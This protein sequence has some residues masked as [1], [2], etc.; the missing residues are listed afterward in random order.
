MNLNAR[1]LDDLIR[2]FTR[3]PAGGFIAGIRDSLPF[4]FQDIIFYINLAYQSGLSLD[5]TQKFLKDNLGNEKYA[6][7]EQYISN[8][9]DATIK[10]T[11][12]LFNNI[13]LSVINY[14]ASDTSDNSDLSDQIFLNMIKK[15]KFHIAKDFPS[16]KAKNL[17]HYAMYE[18]MLNKYESKLTNTEKKYMKGLINDK[19]KLLER[20]TQEQKQQGLQQASATLAPVIGEPKVERLQQTGQ[21]ILQPTNIMSNEPAFVNPILD[22]YSVPPP[23]GAPFY[24]TQ[25]PPYLAPFN[26]PNQGFALPSS[27]IPAMGQRY[28]YGLTQ[29]VPLP[30]D[31]IPAEK[32]P[33]SAVPPYSSA[34]PYSAPTP[35]P[36]YS[37]GQP[38]YYGFGP[39]LPPSFGYKKEQ[40][41][42]AKRKQVETLIKEQQL[43]NKFTL[44]KDGSDYFIT[45]AK[46]LQDSILNKVIFSYSQQDAVRRGL[47]EIPPQVIVDGEFVV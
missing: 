42:E 26:R 8:K 7:L 24:S 38:G 27:Y 29:G 12:D 10:T 2:G 3:A 18:Y 32:P 34:P 15:K 13:R 9:K 36:P 21:N 11:A 33:I 14:Y 31:Y 41:N 1:Q 5:G 40:E 47:I 46:K 22:T 39:E 28:N 19:R 45:D 30:A 20:E 35:P 17:H 4:P 43:Q 23:Y 6:Q 16:E 37:T 25:V 44:A